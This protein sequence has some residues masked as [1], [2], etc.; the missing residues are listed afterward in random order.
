MRPVVTRVSPADAEVVVDCRALGAQAGLRPGLHVV[1]VDAPGHRPEARITAL[2]DELELQATLAPTRDAPLG[3]WWQRGALDPASASA[4]T[5]VHAYT[6]ALRVVWLEEAEAQHVARLVVDGVVR[7]IVRARTAGEAVVQA[8]TA[9]APLQRADAP[10][11]RRRTGLWVGLAG[12]ALGSLALGLGLGLGLREPSG[13]HLQL[14]V[15]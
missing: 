9:D 5:A 13:G 14:V 1:R 7:R 6:G 11:K 3:G 4:R 15:P 8:L 12:A 10:H 2:S